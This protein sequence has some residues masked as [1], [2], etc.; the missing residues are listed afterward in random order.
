[1]A[2][3]FQYALLRA[4]PSL[5]RGETINVGVVVHCRRGRFLELRTGVDE[6]RLHGLDPAADVGA[7]RAHLALLERVAAGT[8]PDNPVARLDRSERFGW[9][10]APSST[11]VQPSPVHTGL[12]EDPA[13]TL[14]KL[15]AELVAA[16][17]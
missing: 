1:V 15:F 3:S 16:P 13:A 8:D 9:I 11:L 2:E 14:D 17:G 10:V 4:V 7:V 6:A 12:T 5:A